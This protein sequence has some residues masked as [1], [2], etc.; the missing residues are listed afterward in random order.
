VIVTVVVMLTAQLEV[1]LIRE[2]YGESF[3]VP[4]IMMLAGIFQDMFGLTTSESLATAVF[5][6]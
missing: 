4:Y 5:P 1:A 2:A 3:L 6:G